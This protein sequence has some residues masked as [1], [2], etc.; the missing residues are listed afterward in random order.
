MNLEGR[1]IAVGIIITV[2]MIMKDLLGGMN[3]E[4]AVVVII[5]MMM[6]A[7]DHPIIVT[8]VMRDAA[9]VAAIGGIMI[10]IMIAEII[11]E[12]E[13]VVAIVDAAVKGEAEANIL[14]PC[15][16]AA[17]ALSLAHVM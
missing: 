12:G 15:R 4:A 7:A 10:E 8:V 9:I 13:G 3:E 14:D 17:V 2:E 11:A 16:E 1:L 6:T 5:I